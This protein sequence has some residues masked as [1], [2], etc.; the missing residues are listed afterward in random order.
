MVGVYFSLFLTF[1]VVKAA[2]ASPPEP[3]AAPVVAIA[4][5]SGSESK[6]GFEPPTIEPDTFTAWS[7]NAENWKKWEEFM[8]SPKLELWLDG[9]L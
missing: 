7:E 4:S 9:K 8:A 3:A 5:A 2:S 1:K 6:F